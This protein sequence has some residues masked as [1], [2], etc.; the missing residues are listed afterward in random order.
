MNIA[1]YYVKEAWKG[2]RR[3]A[4]A[5]A[6]SAALI[7][8]ALLVMG[9]LLMARAGLAGVSHYLHAQL[10]IKVYVEEGIDSARVADILAEQ[11][12][13]ASASLQTGEQLLEQLQSFFAGKPYLLEAF[14]DGALPDA[15]VLVLKEAED[16]EVAAQ[17]LSRMDGIQQVVY[18]QELAQ[19]LVYWSGLLQSAGLAVLAFLLALAFMIVFLA[20]RLALY[21]RSKEIR[22]KLLLG[23]RAGH[24]RGQFLLEGAVVGLA[25]GAG[26]ALVLS[27]LGLAV[28]RRL[29]EA[30]GEILSLDGPAIVVLALLVALAGPILAAA[31]SYAAVRKRIRDA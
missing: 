21:Q 23:A 12:F 4:G 6:A 10:E 3:N 25:G 11:P 20:I 9:L 16:M 19:Q 14:R 13:V 7:L 5:S 24:V 15:V 27:A 30:Y 17:E 2:V 22:L 1:N 26:A 29:T 31:A 8:A 18:P 28:K